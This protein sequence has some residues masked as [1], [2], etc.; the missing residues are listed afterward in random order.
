MPLI[1]L[2][3]RRMWQKVGIL[4]FIASK[5]KYTLIGTEYKNKFLP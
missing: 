3:R 1:V 4:N 5:T 2:W